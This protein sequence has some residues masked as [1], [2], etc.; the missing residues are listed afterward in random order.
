MVIPAFNRSAT[1]S[2]AVTSVLSQSVS[3]LEVIVVDDASTDDTAAMLAA[4]DDSRLRIVRHERNQGACVARNTGLA[5]ARAPLI[6]FQDSDDEWHAGKLEAQ[7]PLFEKKRTSEIIVYC[8]F[9]RKTGEYAVQVPGARDRHRRGDLLPSLLHRNIV[10]TQTLIAPRNCLLEVG[11]FTPKL[12]RLQ[13]WD[14]AIRLAQKYMFE[15]VDTPLVTVHTTPTSIT[16]DRK[17]FLAACRLLLQEHSDLFSSAPDA[18]MRMRLRIANAA[19]QLGDLAVARQYIYPILQ[20]GP[21]AI[22]PMSKL[23]GS[24][25]AGMIRQ[26]RS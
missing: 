23:I 12:P 24:Q 22:P 20:Q 17:A 1:I 21:K 10:S 6:A 8:A 18:E 14:L 13:D 19:I 7:L 3:D 2:R 9:V 15:F 5:A 4:I 25:M 11:G 16:N 26:L